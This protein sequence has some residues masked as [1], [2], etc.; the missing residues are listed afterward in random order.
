MADFLLDSWFLSF[1]VRS[2]SVGLFL[3]ATGEEFANLSAFVSRY[4]KA[5]E[6]LSIL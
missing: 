5:P 6:S 4:L 1:R 2:G 3:E